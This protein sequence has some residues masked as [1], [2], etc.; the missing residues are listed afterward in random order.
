MTGVEMLAAARLHAPE[1]K[2]VLFT[3]YADT[4]VAIRAINEIGLDYYLLKP[5]NPPEENLYPVLDALLDDWVDAHPEETARR[6]GRGPPL[7]GA[8]PRDQDVPRPQPRALPVAGP[9]ARRRGP[10][11]QRPGRGRTRRPAARRAA[12]AGSLRRRRP[13]TSPT[14]WACARPPSSPC[15]TCA[16]SAADRPGWRPRCTGRPRACRRWWSN[17]R[18]PAARPV[19]ARRSRTTSGSPGAVGGRAHAPCRHP[20]PPVRRGD[21]AGARR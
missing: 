2:L 5:W 15:T 12:R 14:P 1:S 7:V 18:R 11:A 19:R 4:E 17:A 8:I 3:A 16:S 20:G 9:G 10:A 13:S 21:G 6:P